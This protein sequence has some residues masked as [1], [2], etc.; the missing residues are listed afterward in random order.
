VSL[1]RK[2]LWEMTAEEA[3]AFYARQDA[4]AKANPVKRGQYLVDTLSCTLCHSAVDEHK[5]LIPGLRLAGGLRIH[6]APYGE[7]ATGNLTSDKETGLGNW[8]D[9]EIKRVITKGILRDGTRLLPFPMDW[10][11]FST[12][13][14]DD[15]NAIVAYL[16]T[17]PPVRNK[18]PRPSWTFLP[19]HLWGKFNLL[20]LGAD[21]PLT[22][23]GG[24]A[25]FTGAEGK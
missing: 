7:F 12:M 5:Q 11:S 9:D 13:K 19:V 2:P 17:V 10:P 3:A 20:I 21:P 15:L 18:V 4:E 1:A 6:V 23:Y 8:T 22:V 25:G 14:E 16:R 24:N